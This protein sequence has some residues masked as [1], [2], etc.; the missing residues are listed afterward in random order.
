MMGKPHMTGTDQSESLTLER[1]TQPMPRP[2]RVYEKSDGIVVSGDDPVLSVCVCTREAN[3][4]LIVSA[5]NSH[6]AMKEAIQ[7]ALETFDVIALEPVKPAD[8]YDHYKASRRLAKVAAQSIRSALAKVAA[9]S[10]E[11]V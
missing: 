6:D 7:Q 2:W 9:P 8:G 5:V 4:A 10:T 1:A 11:T 3:S